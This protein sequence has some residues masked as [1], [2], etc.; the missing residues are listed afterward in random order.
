MRSLVKRTVV[1]VLAFRFRGTPQPGVNESIGDTWAAPARTHSRAL[2]LA[3]R[4][5]ADGSRTVRAA[6][7][8]TW[9]CRYL[10]ARTIGPSALATPPRRSTLIAKAA[11]DSMRTFGVKT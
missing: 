1:A 5:N 8:R 9:P 10:P 11:G 6:A 7:E 2:Q 4:D 3:G